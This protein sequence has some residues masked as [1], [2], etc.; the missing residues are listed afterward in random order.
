[1]TLNRYILTWLQVAHGWVEWVTSWP[2]AILSHSAGLVSN[3]IKI[4]RYASGHLLPIYCRPNPN[5]SLAN[6]LNW[7]NRHR[8]EDLDN[9]ESVKLWPFDV[10]KDAMDKCHNLDV[11]GMCQKLSWLYFVWIWDNK[12]L[13]ASPIITFKLSSIAKILTKSST[14]HIL[15]Y[16]CNLKYNFKEIHYK[17]CCILSAPLNFPNLYRTEL[18]DTDMTQSVIGDARPGWRNEIFFIEGLFVLALIA[19]EW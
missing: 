13:V 1:M 12:R 10:L 18:R 3:P 6:C 7:Q 2:V 8:V 17:P 15:Q 14:F 9:N 4:T 11:H 16:Y 19:M 5:L